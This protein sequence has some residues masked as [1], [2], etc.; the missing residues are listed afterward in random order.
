MGIEIAFDHSASNLRKAE[1]VVV[2]S[3]IS[4]SNPEIKEAKK[5]LFL[6]LQGLR[7]FLV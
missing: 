1:M 6:F 2:S 5:I 4:E 7:C 3:A